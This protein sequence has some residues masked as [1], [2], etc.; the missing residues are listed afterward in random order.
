MGDNWG[1]RE[2]AGAMR[3]DV[4]HVTDRD[5]DSI[6]QT[7]GLAIWARTA[8]PVWDSSVSNPLQHMQI[9]SRLRA[10]FT[11]HERQTEWE[12]EGWRGEV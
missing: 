3:G 12:S 8:V 6:E 2:L 5:G 10:P 4:E 7:H 1:D 9:K 11:S